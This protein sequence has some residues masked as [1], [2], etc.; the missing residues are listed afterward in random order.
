M[1]GARQHYVFS[2]GIDGLVTVGHSTISVRYRDPMGGETEQTSQF[3]FR[4][5][6]HLGKHQFPGLN[7]D[8]VDLF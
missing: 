7:A 3:A 5:L 2:V 6:R 8:S 1:S 4:T